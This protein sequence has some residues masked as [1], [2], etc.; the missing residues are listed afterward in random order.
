MGDAQKSNWPALSL[1][2]HDRSRTSL[3]VSW[4]RKGNRE[5]SNSLKLCEILNVS[6]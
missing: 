2:F 6:R 1:V 3:A 4:E 5:D